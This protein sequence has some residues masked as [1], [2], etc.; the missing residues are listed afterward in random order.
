V[1]PWFRFGMGQVCPCPSL[2]GFARGRSDDVLLSVG[3][4][5]AGPC[6]SGLP[7]PVGGQVMPC[8]VLAWDRQ[9][10]A[11]QACFCPWEVR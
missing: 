8:V 4:G 6:P 7:L 3:I 11:L 9:V 5:Q 1:M 2:T 10:P